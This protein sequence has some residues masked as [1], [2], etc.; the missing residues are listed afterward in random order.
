MNKRKKKEIE[1]EIMLL[2]PERPLTRREEEMMR[3]T[4]TT[5]T[6]GNES[7]EL[8]AGNLARFFSQLDPNTSV[9]N[10][11]EGHFE[12]HASEEEIQHLADFYGAND[13]VPETYECDNCT[14]PE[15]K[16]SNTSNID[17]IPKTAIYGYAGPEVQDIARSFDSGDFAYDVEDMDTAI[18][19]YVAHKQNELINN[20]KGMITDTTKNIMNNLVEYQNVKNVRTKNEI[21]A[22]TR[23]K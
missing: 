19:M 16:C 11:G 5:T 6:P 13:E 9:Y 17:D 1:H 21:I 7:K 18:G 23:V 22:I 15:C 20:I 4:N 14:N 8:K 2:E 3:K 10:T 12:V